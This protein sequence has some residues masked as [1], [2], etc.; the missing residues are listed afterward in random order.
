M[1]TAAKWHKKRLFS[2]EGANHATWNT[3]PH[4]LF[5]KR[6]TLTQKIARLA[7]DAETYLPS[8]LAATWLH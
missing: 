7:T 8:A 1:Q 5:G 6:E 4:S 2:S 3:L